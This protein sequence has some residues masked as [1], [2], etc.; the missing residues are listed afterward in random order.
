MPEK[1]NSISRLEWDSE[2]FNLEVGDFEYKNFSI[3]DCSDF[4]LVYIKSANDVDFEIDGFEKTYTETK[5]IFRR[6]LTSPN[7]QDNSI[8]ESSQIDFSIAD[9]NQLAYESGKYSRFKLDHK[10]NQKKF[11]ELYDLWVVNSLNK[12]FADGVYLFVEEAKAVGFVTYKIS[13]SF[14]TIG[15]IAVSP[16]HQGKGIGKKL[17]QTVENELLKANI[18]ELRIP[19]QE[20]NKQACFFYEKL[21]YKKFEVININHFWKK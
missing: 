10:M 17:L 20:A 9:V 11:F 6:D 14:A 15:L 12:K 21:G 7:Q 2:F 1:M 13:N 8:F 3:P 16:N 5:I 4:D 19:T 18:S